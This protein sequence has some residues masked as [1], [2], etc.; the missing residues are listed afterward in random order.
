MKKSASIETILSNAVGIS[1]CMEA[2]YS[3]Q[4]SLDPFI[5]NMYIDAYPNPKASTFYGFYDAL[6]QLE[7]TL[8][9]CEKA[10]FC[11]SSEFSE[12]IETESKNNNL[13]VSH[14]DLSNEFYELMIN[15]RNEALI[16]F[17]VPSCIIKCLNMSF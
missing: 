17:F 12:Y 2:L 10:T 15:S 14:K 8:C 4:R 5:N 11:N 1:N 3:V 13:F 7:S 6:I 16:C 9:S